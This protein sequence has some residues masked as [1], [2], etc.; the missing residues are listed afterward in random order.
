[1][2]DYLKMPTG[3]SDQPGSDPNLCPHV[4]MLKKQGKTLPK[5]SDKLKY[6]EADNSDSE[7]DSE[8]EAPKP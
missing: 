8:E 3:H 2:E 4:Q 1:M 5:S 7:T 6:Q